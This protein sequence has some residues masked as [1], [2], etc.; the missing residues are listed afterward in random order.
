M[1]NGL[2]VTGARGLVGSTI[3]CE[4]PINRQYDL[5]N[6]IDCDLM[7]SELKPTSVIHCAAKVGGIS[8]NMRNKGQFFYDNIMINTNVVEGCRKFGVEKLIGFLSTCVFPDHVTYPLTESKIHLGPPHESNYAYAYAKR[9]LDIQIRAYREEYGVNYTT[10]IPTNVYGPNDNFS[11]N[12]GHVIPMLIHKVYLAQKNN[13]NLE[14]WG[15]GKAKREFIYSYDVGNITT[16]LLDV[17]NDSEPL[18]LSNSIEITIKDLVDLI[19]DE[20]NF[21][22]KI[23]FDSSKP[24][25]QL[26]KPTDNSQLKNV[27][28]NFKFTPIELGLKRTVEWFIKN[29]DNARK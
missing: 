14:V 25:G 19:V 12:D 6:K 11:L 1:S 10:V 24:E 3:K 2:L 21:K 8:A 15:S 9:M 7:F 5:C 27:L 17:Y 4:F 29:Y 20:F 23:I 16:E 13:T 26:R 18:I 22:G 28:P